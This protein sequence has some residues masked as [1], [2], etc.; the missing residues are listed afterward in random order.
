MKREQ[1]DDPIQVTLRDLMDEAG[2][3]FR[4]LA[5][6]TKR[7]DRDGRGL[8]AGY[9]SNV[10]AGRDFTSERA[11][12]LLAAVFADQIEDAS[13]FPEYRM[14]VV[15]REI[16]ERA[17]GFEQAYA[18]FQSLIASAPGRARR[19]GAKEA[20]RPPAKTA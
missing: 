5:A 17:V 1:T 9:L 18:R 6:E 12:E 20:P 15:R 4:A 2:L 11:L 3:T 10:T 16:N 14:A 8:T 7:V 19:S 13:Y